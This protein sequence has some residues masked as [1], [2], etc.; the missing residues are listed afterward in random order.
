MMS[1]LRVVDV[2]KHYVVRGGRGL[3]G[4]PS[5]V[6]HALNG[7]SVAM[8]EGET[9]GCVG[10]SGCGKSTLAKCVLG[11]ETPTQGT[12]WVEDL[13]I[14]RLDRHQRRQYR[15]RVQAVFQDPF[16]SLNPRM[17][18]G[19]SIT[20]PLEIHHTLSRR[21]LMERAQVLLELVELPH[22][23]AGLYPHEF[24]GGQRQR[25]ALARALSLDPKLI[26]LDEPVSALDV[27]TK[28]QMLNVLAELQDR[29]GVGYFFISHD[30]GAVSFVS[31]RIGVMYAGRKVEE[32]PAAAVVTAP[33]HPYTRELV[34]AVELADE[35]GPPIVV[36]DADLNA[37]VDLRGCPFRIR[38]PKAMAICAEAEPALME[39]AQGRHVACFLHHGQ[40]GGNASRGFGDEPG[41]HPVA[42]GLS[43]P[44]PRTPKARN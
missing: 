33:L 11:L 7:I 4:V 24:S 21:E 30:I 35:A 34:C 28:A 40:A 41:R 22:T 1:L 3:F 26:V 13:D 17:R 39:V 8:A 18:V 6:T 32:G 31:R 5:N 16:S 15:R 43:G 20:E 9:Y 27:S 29:R 12:V 10:E 36:P 14:S 25:I 38:C 2:H 42:V 44:N 23:A 37:T 19:D